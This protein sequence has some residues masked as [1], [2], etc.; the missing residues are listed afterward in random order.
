MVIAIKAFLIKVS[1]IQ[2]S[3]IGQINAP[4][5]SQISNIKQVKKRFN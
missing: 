3:Q 1:I 4:I 2:M 5:Y